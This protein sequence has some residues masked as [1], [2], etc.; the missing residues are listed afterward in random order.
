MPFRAEGDGDRIWLDKIID[1]GLTPTVPTD[2]E[3]WQPL[4]WVLEVPT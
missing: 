4:H 3:R 2:Y 1:D